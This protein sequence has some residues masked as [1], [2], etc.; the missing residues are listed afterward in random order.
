[1]F[2]IEVNARGGA[3]LPVA[4]GRALRGRLAE[5]LGAVPAQAPVVVMVHGY[6]YS[7]FAPETD[8]HRQVY[9]LRPGVDCW[10]VRSWPRGLGFSGAGGAEGFCIGFGWHATAPRLASGLAEV[11]R[12]S[13][14]AAA[15]LT[16]L[17]VLIDDLAP[18]R[19]VDL[20]AHSLGGRV[21]LAALAGAP[22]PLRGRA[23]L[24]GAADYRSGAEAA[25][26]NPS[27]RGV[28][29]F[30]I[31]SRENDL[32]DV[33]FRSIVPPQTRRDRVL[34][35]GLPGAPPRWVDLRI[36][37]PATLAALG[38]RGLRIAPRLR[39]HCHWS[40][41]R[42]PGIWGLYRAILRERGG[43]SASA[44]NRLLPE[45]APA[46]ETAHPTRRAPRLPDLQFGGA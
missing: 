36:D 27:A 12:R 37:D 3:L 24:L 45:A 34:G 11:H 23:V 6:K 29:F 46:A 18:G 10:K 41:Y 5:A 33:F 13:T 15:A 21:T 39:R 42:R 16:E 43:W 20:F 32:Y 38:S 40:F 2:P 26:A 8:P 31:T 28:E 22:V 19:A 30:N 4:N 17:L 7:P 9:A 14:V 35:T 1:M 44:L 25:L